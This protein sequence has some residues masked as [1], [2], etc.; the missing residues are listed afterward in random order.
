MNSSKFME[1]TEIVWFLKIKTVPQTKKKH[2]KSKEEKTTAREN[3]HT[4]PGKELP[5]AFLPSTKATIRPPATYQPRLGHLLHVLRANLQGYA[6]NGMRA[7]LRPTV[8]RLRECNS[9]Y[10]T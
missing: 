2:G 1:T 7:R 9:M 8:L 6:Q 10:C 5:S 3:E 4:L